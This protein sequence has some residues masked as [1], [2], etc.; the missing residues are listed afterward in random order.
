MVDDS[1]GAVNFIINLKEKRE[2]KISQKAQ[3]PSRKATEVHVTS[4]SRSFD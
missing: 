1:D 3:V 4:Q 2:K